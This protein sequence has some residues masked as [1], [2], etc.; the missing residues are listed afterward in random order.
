MIETS[1][2]DNNFSSELQR[3]V[4]GQVTRQLSRPKS[5]RQELSHIAQNFSP[6]ARNLSRITRNFSYVTRDKK[7]S[8]QIFYHL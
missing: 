3:M 7:S 4:Y 5:C 1:N 2:F 8:R 6:V